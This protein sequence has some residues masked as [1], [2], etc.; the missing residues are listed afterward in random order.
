M[1]LCKWVGAWSRGWAEEPGSTEED[2]GGLS[3]WHNPG[4]LR[5][6]EAPPQ[7]SE[8]EDSVDYGGS[9]G[10]RLR[11]WRRTRPAPSTASSA[12]ASSRGSGSDAHAHQPPAGRLRTCARAAPTPFCSRPLAPWVPPREPLVRLRARLVL[13]PSAP[14][15]PP[16][17]QIGRGARSPGNALAAAFTVQALSPR[18]REAF[19]MLRVT[20]WPGSSFCFKCSRRPLRGREDCIV[21]G[22]LPVSLAEFSLTHSSL[23]AP[24]PSLQ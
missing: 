24:A 23:A 19:V 17:N 21:P 22:S 10:L 5:V 6:R 8:P 3:N 15:P 11:T 13:G 2:C 12:P 14:F 20:W 16:S 9:S 18:L 1:S 4:Q 7:A